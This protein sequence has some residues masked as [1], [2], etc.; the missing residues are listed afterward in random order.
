MAARPPTGGTRSQRD[1]APVPTAQLVAVIEEF[2]AQFPESALLEDGRALF[3]M[4]FSRY[5][6]AEAHGRCVL[7]LWNDERNLV[8]TVLS[9]EARNGSLR[10]ITRKMGAAKPVA[11]DFIGKQDR[12]A[13]TERDK[14][15]RQYLRLLERVLERNFP[16]AKLDGFRSATDLEHSFGPAYVRGHLFH[17]TSA[18]AV[19]GVSSDESSSTIDGILTLGLLWL[20]HC[21]EHSLQRRTGPV[22]HF[23]ALK[24]IVPAGTFKTTAERMLW[25][26]QGA[27]IF[28][29]F[30]LDERSEELTEIDFRDTG[31][32][33][34]RL[35][36]AFDVS[37]A[38]ERAQPSIDRIRQL[39]PAKSWPRVEIRAQAATEVGL[40]LHG[41]EFA[42]IRTVA[43]AHSFAREEEI[44]FGAGANETR[45]TEETEPLCRDLLAQLFLSRHPDGE[46]PDPL[47]RLQPE[48]WLESRIRTELEETLPGLRG[49]FLYSQ[50]PAIGAGERGMLDLL[51]LDRSGRLVILEVKADEDMHLP[52]QGLDYWIRV[53]AL[54][55]ERQLTGNR[56]TGAFERQGYFVQ[57]GTQAQ[58]AA[59]PPKLLL[60][61]PALRIHPSNEIVLRYL[62][63]QVDWELIAVSEHWRRELKVVF[64]KRS[65]EPVTR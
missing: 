31:N 60:I 42:R 22:R 15:R 39:I 19:I 29:L 56:D 55:A 7:Q 64:R 47:F 6:V 33:D 44:T 61:A 35:V 32:V 45:L 4:R 48:R 1:S 26:N 36:H 24:V 25:L 18:E 3:D 53:R 63:P 9:T 12:R 16:G 14:V 58:V 8:R 30:T 20:D 62:A 37:F 10:L 2:L 41:L 51:T 38:L 57:N 52:L 54:N 5:S 13:P 43:S 59:A 27:A 65:R 21:R 17:G 34:S 40:L 11:L 46:R 50:V 49:E 23:G 28:Q